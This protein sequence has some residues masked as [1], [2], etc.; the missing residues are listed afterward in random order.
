[1]E[2]TASALVKLHISILLAGFT[3][4]FGKLISLGEV[5]LVWWR[6][7]M[8]AAIMFPLLKMWNKFRTYPARETLV[9]F[10][11]GGLQ[12][13]H[14]VLF[15][16]SIKLSTVS[17]ALVCISLMGFFSAIFSPLI[18]KTRWSIR[19]FVY[20]GITIVGIA[21]IFHFD[22]RYRLGIAVGIVSSAIASLFVV[23]N[24]RI[25]GGYE[26]SLL[27]F[28][29]IVG[30]LL[31]VTLY[32]PAHLFLNPGDFGIPGALDLFYLLL[33]SSVCT[34][35]LYVIQLQALRK[36]S[37]FTVNLS[38]NLEPIYSIILAS[39]FL[40]ESKDFTIS[41]YAGLFLIILSV[42]LQTLHVLKERR[43][44]ITRAQTRESVR[45][46]QSS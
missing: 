33:L 25:G 43:R 39:I 38:L 3:G 11:V 35:V 31:L 21:M 10:G 23:Y 18:L 7:L 29:E 30:G 26:S 22:T 5:P 24:K 34:V 41:F 8:V 1:M 13:L 45:L 32:L 9:L 42:A 12:G 36:V 44:G 15:Y 19:E 20:S 17:V 27:F 37:A 14:W 28:Y 40:G 4:V 16:A 2:T 46:P 6:L